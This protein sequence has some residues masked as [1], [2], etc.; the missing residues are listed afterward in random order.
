MKRLPNPRILVGVAALLLLPVFVSPLWSIRLVAPQYP[1]GLGM[2]IGI[3]DIHEHSRHDLQNINILNHYIGMQEIVPE[4]IPELRIMPVILGVLVVTGLLAAV[5]GHRWVLAGWLAAFL[6][7]GVVGMVDFYMW[8]VDYGTN[9]SP[10]APIRI[11]GMTYQPP[12]IGTKQLL[13]ITANSYPTWGTLFV[14]L[15][16]LSGALGVYESFRRKRAG[17][18]AGRGEEAT[19]G[20]GERVP[21]ARTASAD[22]DADDD[23]GSP[24]RRIDAG[25]L[26]GAL[27]L[28]LL[29]GACGSAPDERAAP[30]GEPRNAENSLVYGED[31]D[32]YCGEEV[33]R[34]RWGGEIRTTQGE[35]L[36]FRSVECLAGFLLAGGVEPGA[37][38]QVRVVDFEDGW[39][40]VDARE[41]VFLHSPNLGSPNG[42][43][44]HALANPWMASRMQELYTG[45]L[46]EWDRVLEL[47]A[48]EWSIP[49]G[50]G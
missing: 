11:P 18:A 22:P 21:A 25:L 20:P 36:R 48:R 40:L 15:A 19:G 32:P 42:L 35:R 2:S 7:L 37:V 17:G 41:A 5:I 24:G 27:V 39:R 44:L 38:D 31:R 4:E 16:A 49:A 33:D 6:G 13:N 28:P 34:V 23:R 10:D 46:L 30:E 8:K 1:Q 12:L 43:N 50:G 47:V 45:P 9:L 3:S 14:T 26:V 29:I